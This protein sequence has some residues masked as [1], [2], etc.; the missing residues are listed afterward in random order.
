MTLDP[1]TI[2]S[3]SRLC[4]EEPNPFFKILVPTLTLFGHVLRRLKKAAI[5][6]PEVPAKAIAT[7]FGEQKWADDEVWERGKNFILD[8]EVKSSDLSLNEEKQVKVWG[9]VMKDLK[10]LEEL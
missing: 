6:P 1:G 7:M 9:F 8:D 2:N 10:L 4:G 5:N 3:P